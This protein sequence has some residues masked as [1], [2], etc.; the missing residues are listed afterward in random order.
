MSIIQVYAPTTSEDIL[1]I[2]QFYNSLTESTIRMRN[3]GYQVIIMGDWNSPIGKDARKGHGTMGK[4]GGEDT[5][6]ENGKKMLD[7]CITNN[8]LIGNTFFPHKNIHKF[9]FKAGGTGITTIIDYITYTSD[10]R[11]MDVKVNRGAEL[12]TDHYLLVLTYRL[13]LRHKK[14]KTQIYTKIKTKRLENEESRKDYENLVTEKLE[15]RTQTDS[16]EENWNIFKNIIIESAEEICGRRKLG[17]K[18]KRTPWWND[19]VKEAV[20]QK[21]KAWEKY[22]R[23]N[24][25]EDRQIYK[26]KRNESRDKLKLSKR[27]S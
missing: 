9:T 22:L 20:S 18:K 6:N 15:Q 24:L 3:K 1:E 5:R 7:F 14:T 16:L 25:E 13:K 10:T 17:N 12:D 19:T 21:K 8:I 26:T 4:H 23:T 2:E 11:Y 27:K